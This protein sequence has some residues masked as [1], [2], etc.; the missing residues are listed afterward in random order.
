M[1]RILFGLVLI[2]SS[3]AYGQNTN[4]FTAPSGTCNLGP[5]TVTDISQTPAQMY[6]CA[7]SD[8]HTWTKVGGSGGGGGGASF[9]PTGIQYATSSTV[10][11]VAS[12]AE[13]A[14]VIGA[15][16]VT[17]ATNAVNAT[18]ATNAVAANAVGLVPFEGTVI[19]IFKT[20]NGFDN[21]GQTLGNAFAL[22][23]GGSGVRAATQG[24]LSSGYYRLNKDCDTSR[25]CRID[26]KVLWDPTDTTGSL[27][28][29]LG[30]STN[31]FQVT[32]NNTASGTLNA[33]FFNVAGTTTATAGVVGATSIELTV[34]MTIGNGGVTT[35]VCPNG[36]QHAFTAPNNWLSCQYFYQHLNNSQ[37]LNNVYIGSTSATSTV[38]G[39]M[40]NTNGLDGDPQGRILTRA[41]AQNIG[42]TPN[43]S[44][45]CTTQIFMDHENV[46]Y[47]A[48]RANPSIPVKTLFLFHGRTSNGGP[49]NCGGPNQ[50][51]APNNTY[52]T[53]YTALAMGW[54]VISDQGGNGF[55]NMYSDYWGGP[56]GVEY[57]KQTLETLKKN[58]YN[59]GK[60]YAIGQSMGGVDS[61]NYIRTYPNDI[62]AVYEATPAID[63]NE[64][65]CPLGIACAG[66]TLKTTMDTAYQLRYISVLAGTNTGNNPATDSGTNWQVWSEAGANPSVGGR[67]WQ[68]S[69]VT[70]A[71]TN[72][73]LITVIAGTNVNPGDYVYFTNSQQT[74]RVVYRAGTSNLALGLDSAI[75][76]QANETVRIIKALPNGRPD[77]T[78]FDFFWVN[79]INGGIATWNVGT[80]YTL[81]Q[82][83]YLNSSTPDSDEA[84]WNP[85]RHPEVYG[86][87]AIE[88]A[89]AGDGTCG[90]NDGILNNQQMCDFATAVNAIYPGTATV[91]GVIG[92]HVTPAM[93][94]TLIFGFFAL[95]P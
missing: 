28:V 20:L 70:A 38:V 95:H 62:T 36:A 54:N 66:S 27:Q 10:A 89:I 7:G 17:N 84:A 81:G 33:T 83:V 71:V 69:T 34:G 56:H 63:L 8:G 3:C 80:G 87:V 85:T 30:P 35:Y 25:I 77:P 1:K 49:D 52:S 31:R 22:G 16:A 47:L 18:N 59:A 76:T 92:G 42:G 4:V 74:R 11:H 61:L 68:F 23:S 44:A 2:A 32:L 75:T 55:T 37:R 5:Q 57:S 41:V 40:A 14:A 29:G 15:T 19:P 46:M 13:I 67:S 50:S 64:T 82:V 24:T 53:C 73:N 43:C 88:I 93:D 91:I 48:E 58:I 21:L 9:T 78:A 79:S 65:S 6:V 45:G 51:A 26:F 60:T 94:P 72:A 39:F 90:S 12:G 86:N